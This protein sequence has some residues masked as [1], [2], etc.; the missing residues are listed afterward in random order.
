MT[1]RTSSVRGSAMVVSFLGGRRDPVAVEAV[2][3]PVRH[4][5]L[6]ERLAR[7]VPRVEHEERAR[8]PL[9]VV[10][11]HEHVAVVL[12]RRRAAWHEERLPDAVAGA[13]VARL[14]RAALEVVLPDRR[15]DRY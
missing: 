3:N 15:P 13:E 1:C 11:E 14:R 2:G 10:V 7:D 12:A 6:R 8:V 4:P 5:N 9:L